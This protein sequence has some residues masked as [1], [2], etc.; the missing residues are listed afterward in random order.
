[1][2]VR[3]EFFH[4][5]PVTFFGNVSSPSQTNVWSGEGARSEKRERDAAAERIRS[6]KYNTTDWVLAETYFRKALFD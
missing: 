5:A 1:V 2:D 3:S 6:G 4:V